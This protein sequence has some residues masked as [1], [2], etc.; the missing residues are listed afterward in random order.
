MLLE[1]S[2]RFTEVMLLLSSRS[3]GEL[4]MFAFDSFFVIYRHDREILQKHYWSK[5]DFCRENL[6]DVMQTDEDV[7]WTAGMPH[8]VEGQD[9]LEGRQEA[10]MAYH[11]WRDEV[12]TDLSSF[13]QHL[14]N[15]NGEGWTSERNADR[16]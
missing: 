5:D 13:Q 2:Q 8:E 15:Q 14:I 4:P 6:G 1:T 9:P 16:D 11:Q 3:T 10:E 12:C 7:A